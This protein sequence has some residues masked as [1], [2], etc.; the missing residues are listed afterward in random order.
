MTRCFLWIERIR[1]ILIICRFLLLFPW[2]LLKATII[3]MRRPEV[4]AVF[5][6][7]DGP[8]VVLDEEYDTMV[9]AEMNRPGG[10]R[11]QIRKMAQ[12]F[13]AEHEIRP[14]GSNRWIEPS[15]N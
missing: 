8:R 15:R 11:E 2:W 13:L 5:I 7:L 3:V 4:A 12:E 6:E 10:S 14:R 9:E 1:E